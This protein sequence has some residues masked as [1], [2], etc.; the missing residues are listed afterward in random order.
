M[1][2]EPMK[3]IGVRLSDDLLERLDAYARALETKL[4]GSRVTRTDAI[5]MCVVGHLDR[6]G[7]AKE[8]KRAAGKK[9]PKSKK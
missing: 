3:V 9:R 5:R 8:E 2:D 1:A 4:P 7:L 6:V